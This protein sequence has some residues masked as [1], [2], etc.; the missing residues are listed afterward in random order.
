MKTM[1]ATAVVTILLAGSAHAGPGWGVKAGKKTCAN[2]KTKRGW[3]V[4]GPGDRSLKVG[5]VENPNGPDRSGIYYD[6][7]NCDLKIGHVERENG[8]K[9]SGFSYDGVNHDFQVGY[10]NRPNGPDRFGIRFR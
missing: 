8:V 5:H 10:V 7:V 1:M 6:G 9:K 2:G 3:V 4:K